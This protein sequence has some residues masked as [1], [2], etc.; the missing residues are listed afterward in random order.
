MPRVLRNFWVAGVVDGRK[1]PI[2]GGPRSRD[3]GVNLTVYQR[4]NGRAAVA[5]TIEGTASRD[6][7]LRLA[8]KARL[9]CEV[10][11]AGTTLRI[12]TT[13]ATTLRI[14]TTR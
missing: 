1:C 8:I 3:G 7:T 13:P 2:S 5:L 9:P 14:K 11:C 6:G 4:N 12:K 10:T